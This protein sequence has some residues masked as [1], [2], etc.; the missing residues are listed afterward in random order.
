MPLL[1]SPE[2]FFKRIEIGINNYEP[3]IFMRQA[4]TIYF[5]KDKDRT[6]SSG[7]EIAET[8]DYVESLPG[9]KSQMPRDELQVLRERIE[10]DLVAFGEFQASDI[11]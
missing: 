6:D 3:A 11:V 2:G 8:L 5:F 10:N 1:A 7:N 9:L 4:F